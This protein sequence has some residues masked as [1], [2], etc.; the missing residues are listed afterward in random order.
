M[1]NEV[2]KQESTEG[3]MEQREFES[4]KIRAGEGRWTGLPGAM[5]ADFRVIKDR[6]FKI[7]RTRKR[8]VQ[9]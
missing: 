9:R 6:I 5:G 7:I 8:M 1:K 4:S 3:R 2:G